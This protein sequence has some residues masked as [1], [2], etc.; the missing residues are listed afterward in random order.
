MLRPLLCFLA[1]AP[2]ALAQPPPQ[3]RP[4]WHLEQ[5]PRA[6]QHEALHDGSF[7]HHFQGIKRPLPTGSGASLPV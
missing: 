1:L 4:F 7:H 2:S 3:A 5:L 6:N